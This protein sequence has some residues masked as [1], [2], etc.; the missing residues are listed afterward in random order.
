M[1]YNDELE[2][3]ARE[4][5]NSLALCLLSYSF[6]LLNGNVMFSMHELVSQQAW[7]GKGSELT[8]FNQWG[9]TP[10]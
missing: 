10:L 1:Y 6:N 7:R 8:K 5:D 3:D 2:T 9:K 4:N